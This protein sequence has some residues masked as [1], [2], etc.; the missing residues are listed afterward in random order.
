MDPM[1]LFHANQQW[2]TRP[3]DERF[4]TLE[5]MHA[6]TLAYAQ[7]AKVKEV[8]WSDL[9]VEAVGNDLNLIGR[10]GVPAQLTNYAFGQLS[11][12]VGAPAGYLRD[13]PATLAA[14]NLNH[15]LKEKGSDSAQ[16]LFHQNGGLLL[17][18]A[19][20]EK[21]SRIW[22]YEV[23]ERL[24]EVSARNDL[25]PARATIRQDAFGR[26]EDRAL[27]AS[28][29]DMFAFLMSRERGVIDPVGREM[30]RGVIAINSEVGAVALKI[31]AFY[32]R[33]VCGNFIIWGAEQI[34]EISLRHV[35]DIRKGWQNAQV[36]VRR[37]L[38]GAASLETAKFQEMSRV[39]AGSKDEVLDKVFGLRINELSR[40]SI[41]EAYDAVIVSEDGAP[42]TVWGLAQGITRISQREAF[43][44]ER[45]KLD[46]GAGK[47]LAAAFKF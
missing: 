40:K 34:A 19:T 29:H 5:E 1:E 26:P 16:L 7:N 6:A 35:G 3:A 36:S 47:L 28:D 42:N 39:I 15:G 46:K 33:D 38:D 45:H 18:A 17:R 22:N 24:M 9:R 23:I 10:A 43:A 37:Y 32:F 30:Y 13:L 21:Y 14:Q 27:F 20:S 2:S 25:M 8:P 31:M 12:R 4:Q 11:A 44:D 41:S